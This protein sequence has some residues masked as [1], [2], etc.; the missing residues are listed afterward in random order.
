MRVG[1]VSWAPVSPPARGEQGGLLVRRDEHKGDLEAKWCGDNRR[2]IS[3]LSRGY[4]E[5]YLV[6]HQTIN[7]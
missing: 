3:R 7:L 4:H 2:A 1:D 6:K 5:L